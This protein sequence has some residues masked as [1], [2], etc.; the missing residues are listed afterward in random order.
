ML[1]CAPYLERRPAAT[2][3]DAGKV[4]EQQVSFYLGSIWLEV[5]IYPTSQHS[6]DILTAGSTFR[7]FAQS[8]TC[9]CVEL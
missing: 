1:F 3:G 7:L 4:C 2:A 8:A 6:N 9:L 5:S